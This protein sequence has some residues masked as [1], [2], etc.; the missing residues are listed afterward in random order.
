MAFCDASGGD[1]STLVVGWQ[2]CINDNI[3]F[4]HRDR[5]QAVYLDGHV[6]LVGRSEVPTGDEA[7]K[8]PF[9]GNVPQFWQP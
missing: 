9:W 8:N 4:R 6:E 3:A 2:G 5:A 7:W 1:S